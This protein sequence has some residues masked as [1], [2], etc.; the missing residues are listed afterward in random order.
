MYYLSGNTIWLRLSFRQIFEK[1]SGQQLGDVSIK[2]FLLSSVDFEGNVANDVETEQ[3]VY[4]RG[5]QNNITS[6]LHHRGSVPVFWSQDMGSVP[7]KP[8]I[9]IDHK[10][11]W[12]QEY[13]KNAYIV[14]DLLLHLNNAEWLPQ[15]F[16]NPSRLYFCHNA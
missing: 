11:P 13:I 16:Y 14:S 4:R 7:Q 6:F 1:S 12:F 9:Q 15:I 3:I 2:L 8:P 5:F 10:D